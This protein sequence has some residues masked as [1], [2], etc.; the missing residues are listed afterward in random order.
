MSEQQAQME[1]EDLHM[2]V[3]DVYAAFT[4]HKAKEIIALLPNNI[5]DEIFTAII[6]IDPTVK[7]Y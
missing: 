7:A 1:Q 2:S 4:R 6:D 3:Q 5:V